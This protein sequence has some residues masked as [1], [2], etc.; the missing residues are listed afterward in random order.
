MQPAPLSRFFD[1]A[2]S[3]ACRK[4]AWSK[5]GCIAIINAEGTG[6]ETRHLACNPV[7]GAWE[8]SAAYNIGGVARIHDGVR[9]QHVTWSS[10][11][12]DLA[13][14]DVL[15]RV[16][17]YTVYVAINAL[18][19]VTVCSIDQD[20][21]LSALAGFWWLPP[22][23]PYSLHSVVRSEDGIK[24]QSNTYRTFG[25][26]HPMTNK[27]AAIGITRNGTVS[28]LVFQSRTR[29][30]IV[31]QTMVPRW[32]HEIPGDELRPGVSIL[33]RRRILTRCHRKHL[34]QRRSRYSGSL[35]AFAPAPRLQAR[36]QLEYSTSATDTAAATKTNHSAQHAPESDHQ[37]SQD[38]RLRIPGR[39][40]PRLFTRNAHPPGG[41]RTAALRLGSVPNCIVCVFG[42]V[43]GTTT[44]HCGVSVGFEG[45]SLRL[46]PEF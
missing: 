34:E 6:V 42:K 33:T 30:T 36:H 28:G 46:A 13:V 5:L 44:I 45:E 21:D 12:A 3:G 43:G 31:G 39:F 14:V 15:G 25:P 24:Y 32:G 11:G 18:S 40:S 19:L 41:P 38:C 26:F 20:D 7:N 9:L 10:Q 2:D 17:F 16:S 37:T 35:H 29:L 22:E 4:I 23:R 8:L 1:F 27:A